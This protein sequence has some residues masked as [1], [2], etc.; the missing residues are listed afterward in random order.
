MPCFKLFDLSFN[1]H[2]LILPF[3]K[4]VYVKAHELLYQLLYGNSC[5]LGNLSS[6]L[7]WLIGSILLIR[8]LIFSFVVTKL[9][10]PGSYSPSIAIHYSSKIKILQ[11]PFPIFHSFFLFYWLFR[12]S[13]LQLSIYIGLFQPVSCVAL[14]IYSFIYSP[15]PVIFVYF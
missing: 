5:T 9:L 8:T 11:D 6:K 3:L 1:H 10:S 12:L 4:V 2:F 15:S 14:F 7:K 13:F